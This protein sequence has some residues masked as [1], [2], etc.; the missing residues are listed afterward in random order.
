MLKGYSYSEIANGTT[1][2]SAT[3]QV[4]DTSKGLVSWGNAKPVSGITCKLWLVKRIPQNKVFTIPAS[5]RGNVQSLQ[6]P[7]TGQVNDQSFPEIP[8]LSFASNTSQTQVSNGEG[9]VTWKYHGSPS[10]KAGNYD[11]VILTDWSGKTSN[12]SWYDITIQRAD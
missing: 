3:V 1:S 2:Y 10:V 5:T 6:N 11:L 8:G 7:I 12:W 9:Q 4:T